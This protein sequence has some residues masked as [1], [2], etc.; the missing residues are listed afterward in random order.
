MKQ[1]WPG[2]A[3]VYVEAVRVWATLFRVAVDDGGGG[4]VSVTNLFIRMSQGGEGACGSGPLQ[5]GTLRPRHFLYW[6]SRGH[7]D[8]K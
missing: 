3:P 6:V 1:S 8:I 5:D 2:A 7:L 4:A